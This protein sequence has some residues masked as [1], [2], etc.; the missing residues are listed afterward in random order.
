M[1]LRSDDEA[2]E[3]LPL[4]LMIVAIV[5]GMSIGPAASALQALEDRNFLHRCEIELE[6]LISASQA[7]AME[8]TGSRRT[9]EVDLSSD[10]RLRV[11][12]VM[13][14]DAWG[15]PWMT[16]IALELSSGRRMIGSVD[17]PVVWL[18]SHELDRLVVGSDRFDAM[19][20]HDIRSGRQ[21][22]IC[23][24]LPWTS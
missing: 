16:S 6:R 24:V 14:G 12:R 23:E 18:A 19:L 8:G 11:T 2:L 5:A 10:G 22:A 20:S 15:G 9:V 4:R 13:I 17:E 1:R 3:S 21:V 7:V